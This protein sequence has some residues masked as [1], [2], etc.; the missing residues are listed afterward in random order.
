MK[1]AL[2]AYGH[3]N[4]TVESGEMTKI[5]TDNDGLIPKS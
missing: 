1:V 3:E 5:H 2:F 4:S